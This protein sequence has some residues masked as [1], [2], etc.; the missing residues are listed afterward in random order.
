[1]ALLGAAMPRLEPVKALACTIKRHWEGVLHFI[2]SRITTGIVE[3]LNSKIKTAMKRAYGFKSFVYLRT[4]IYLSSPASS[5][6]RHPHNV[7]ENLKNIF[8]LSCFSLRKTKGN[9]QAT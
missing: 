5:T 6:S 2:T 1:M 9:L 3:G 7:E 8:L 4:I